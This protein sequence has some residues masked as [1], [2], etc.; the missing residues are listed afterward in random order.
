M[1]KQIIVRILPIVL[2]VSALAGCGMAKDK[3]AESAEAVET[4]AEPDEAQAGDET[5]A[6][7][8]E[9]EAEGE[10]E[11]AGITQSV[12][13]GI[14]DAEVIETGLTLTT[15]FTDIMEGEDGS[16]I[17]SDEYNKKIWEFKDGEFTVF[18][19]DDSVEDIYGKPMGGYNDAAAD[20]ALFGVPWAVEPFFE[21]VAVSDPDNGAVR[22]IRNGEVETT[23]ASLDGT[24]G[25][26]SYE[27]PTGLASDDEGNL[28]I[29][30]THKG[31]VYVI[32]EDGTAKIV[33]K[34]LEGPMGLC[35]SD[36]SLYVAETGANRISKISPKDES[37]TSG[38]VITEIIA[39]TGETGYVDGA[40]DEAQFS[41]PKCVEVA[42]D[43][44]IYVS[45]TVNSAIRRIKDGQVD[46]VLKAEDS[47]LN[48]WPISPMG[49]LIKDDVLY[50][51]DSYA[52][53]VI[54][55]SIAE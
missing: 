25:V 9:N 52:N 2:A 44:T 24:G 18:A 33:V 1:K 6:D 38:N 31:T 50:V 14:E 23:N 42:E 22:L 32:T 34:N 41:S 51:C 8:E 35:F 49:M 19:G 48:A 15:S 28:Y 30:D 3:P 7:E 43:G 40:A 26:L 20:K 47:D 55:L 11:N 16:L 45:D 36:G 12:G 46:T 5:S 39:G 21:G 13:S 4:A 54:K 17:L 37:L 10:D 27:Y 53:K 29:S